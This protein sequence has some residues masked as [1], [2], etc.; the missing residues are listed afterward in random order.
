MAKAIVQLYY[1]VISVDCSWH[2]QSCRHWV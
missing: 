2:L 1:F